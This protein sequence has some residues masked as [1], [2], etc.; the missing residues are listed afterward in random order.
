[1]VVVLVLRK[2]LGRFTEGEEGQNPFPGIVG[3]RNC[4]IDLDYKMQKL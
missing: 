2:A 3:L 1:M 4:S